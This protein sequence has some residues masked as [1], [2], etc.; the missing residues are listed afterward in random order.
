ADIDGQHAGAQERHHAHADEHVAH[1]GLVVAKPAKAR[2]LTPPLFVFE[3][4]ASYAAC[5][6]LRRATASAISLSFFSCSAACLR[7]SSSCLRASLS[8]CS[9]ALRS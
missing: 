2:H 7:C 6:S 3:T 5:A 4:S 9:A 1:P 8:A